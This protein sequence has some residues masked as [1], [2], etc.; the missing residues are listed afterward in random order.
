MLKL[1]VPTLNNYKV[2]CCSDLNR[3]SPEDI[4]NVIECFSYLSNNKRSSPKLF[5]AVSHSGLNKSLIKLL[6][7]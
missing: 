1:K 7:T 5:L 2:S 6:T 3:R 4:L